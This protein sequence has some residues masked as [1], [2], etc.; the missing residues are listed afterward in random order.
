MQMTIEIK[1]S[2]PTP[3][4]ISSAG[5]SAEAAYSQVLAQTTGIAKIEIINNEVIGAG[6]MLA[7]AQQAVLLHCR[8][9]P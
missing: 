6:Q 7:N 5:I 3:S 9:T 2:L 1:T 8:V 4:S